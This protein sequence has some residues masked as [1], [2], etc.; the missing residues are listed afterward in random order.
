VSKACWSHLKSHF[1]S[2]SFDI[3]LFNSGRI[4]KTL[5]C[6]FRI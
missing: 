3:S 6:C 2:F 1:S 4:Y 5:F